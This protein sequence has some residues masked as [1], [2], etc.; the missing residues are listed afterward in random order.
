MLD[1]ELANNVFG[2][3]EEAESFLYQ[4]VRITDDCAVVFGRDV[5]RVSGTTCYETEFLFTATHEQCLDEQLNPPEN[6]DVNLTY[7]GGANTATKTFIVPVD[8][9]PPDGKYKQ[10]LSLFIVDLSFE[11][12]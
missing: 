9:T 11:I 1:L 5:E 4:N 6:Y 7:P 2:T 12:T 10:H 3:V 8:G